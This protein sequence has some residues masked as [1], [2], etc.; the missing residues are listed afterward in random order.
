[1]KWLYAK[2]ALHRNVRDRFIEKNGFE[3]K[4]KTHYSDDFFREKHLNIYITEKKLDEYLTAR[5]EEM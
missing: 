3:G 2:T 5:F 1:M 4:G